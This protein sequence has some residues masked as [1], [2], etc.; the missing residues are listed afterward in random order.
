MTKMILKAYKIRIYPNKQQIE[1][2]AK[3]LWL[4]QI[5]L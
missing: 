4:L 5:C 3:N 1:Q 2:I